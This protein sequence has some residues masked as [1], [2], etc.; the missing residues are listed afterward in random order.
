MA[1]HGE[2]AAR[3]INLGERR[4]TSPAFDAL[5]QE[6]MALVERTAA[7]LDG[8]GRSAYRALTRTGASL[9]ATHS[10]RLTTRLMQLAS[11]LLLQRAVNEGDLTPGE[12]L[13]EKAK[14]DLGRPERLP[15]DEARLLPDELADLIDDARELQQ[16]ILMLE[17]AL[18]GTARPAPNP[19]VRQ[20]GMLRA[21]FEGH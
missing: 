13:R 14:V 1:D 5:F 6:G 21:A 17:S 7:Y 4:A 11:W 18:T 9:Y 3:A 15:D 16:R 2:S 10:M 8:P 19:V 12:A 20:L